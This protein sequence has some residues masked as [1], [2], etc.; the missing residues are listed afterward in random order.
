MG[1]RERRERE[2]EETRTMILDAAREMFAS[3]GYEA[4]TMRRIAERIEYSPTAIYFHF[5]DKEALIRELCDVDFGSL[6]HQFQAVSKLSYPVEKLKRT[7]LAYV[8]FG[9]D[10]PNHYRLMFMTPHPPLKPEESALKH[11]NPEED[12]YA[13]LK[14]IVAEAIAHGRFRSEYSDVEL[15]SQLVWSG[16]HGIVALEIAK[17]NDPWVAWRPLQKRAEAMVN[18]LVDGL[19][20]KKGK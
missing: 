18:L 9:V 16:M 13:F 17:C 6:A 5:K 7:G 15:T 12:A 20:Q 10:Y 3:E 1:T 11:G 4:V 19:S 2:R 8:Q 14:H